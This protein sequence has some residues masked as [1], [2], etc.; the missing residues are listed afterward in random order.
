MGSFLE[1]YFLKKYLHYTNCFQFYNSHFND[2]GRV[3]QEDHVYS[4]FLI[5]EFQTSII[6]SHIQVINVL[7]PWHVTDL[8]LLKFPIF[9]LYS[10]PANS[11]S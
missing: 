4:F 8:M 6:K 2:A 7:S 1:Y 9:Y 11:K 10:M 3:S 5:T